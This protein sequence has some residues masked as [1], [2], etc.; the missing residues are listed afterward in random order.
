MTPQTLQDGV[1]DDQPNTPPTNPDDEKPSSLQ[2]HT[3]SVLT[4]KE[5]S[6]DWLDSTRP[7]HRDDNNDDNESL[8]KKDMEN[9]LEDD[10]LHDAEDV[11]LN[12]VVHEWAQGSTMHGV[13]GIADGETWK[14]WKRALWLCLVCL[15]GALM[16]W[17]VTSLIQQYKDFEVITETETVVP[18]SLPF[19]EITLCSINLFSKTRIQATGISEP[20]NETELRLITPPV[21]DLIWFTYFN[22]QELWDEFDETTNTTINPV[23]TERIT[24][25]G[26]CWSFLTDESVYRPGIYGGLQLYGI[27]DQDDFDENT[28]LAG[29]LIW[30]EE[31]GTKIHDQLPLTV[32]SPGGES[33]VSIDKTVFDREKEAPWA[34]CFSKA[35]E[36]TQRLCYS[37]CVN[38]EIRNECECRNYGDDLADPD[39]RYC[40]PLTNFDDQNCTE[41][42][43]SDSERIFQA[44]NCSLPP[45]REITYGVSVT[46]A[47]LSNQLFEFFEDLFNATD[48]GQKFFSIRINFKEIGLELLSESKAITREQLLG[49]IGGS[50]GLFLGI[51]AI[52]IFEIFG[53]FL[54]L[55]LIPRL[56]GIRTLYGVGQRRDSA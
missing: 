35:P 22:G 5:S 3:S 19:P 56:F 8:T 7:H 25:F 55:R 4:A 44:C 17:Q 28:P 51:S 38:A 33:I 32:L 40:Q 46:S 21:Q 27:L 13:A 48:F 31:P 54:L 36:Y 2:P 12:L 6:N 52:S 16:V 23:W 20:A 53:D 18:Q 30:V 41:F 37:Q 42:I 11:P 47:Q 29:L 39:L 45:C 10:E 49:S 15:S 14:L 24:D 1:D 34:R 26:K 50:M 43:N 9:P